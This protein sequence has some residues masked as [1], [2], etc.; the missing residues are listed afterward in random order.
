MTH[1]ENPFLW[2]SH[3]FAQCTYVCDVYTR[4]RTDKIVSH[5][6]VFH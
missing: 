2:I 3:D 4:V 1:F 5:D 6:S